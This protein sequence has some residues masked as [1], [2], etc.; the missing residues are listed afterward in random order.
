MVLLGAVAEAPA[1]DLGWIVPERQNLP[2]AAVSS[3]REFVEK[4]SPA[5]AASLFAQG[6][7]WNTML[8]VTPASA[9]WALAKQ[10]LPRQAA[11]LERYAQALHAPGAADLLEDT[12][13]ELPAADFSRDL[14]AAARGL[15]VTPMLGA[16]WSDCGTPE[17]LEAALGD[18]PASS[19]VTTRGALTDPAV[20][21][22]S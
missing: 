7:L 13:C 16:G 22:A 11:L 17:R 6:A 1:S 14:V 8:S 4:P 19:R 18:T 3:I 5:L 15:W 20:A 2:G 9:L 10:Q 12:Y 21:N